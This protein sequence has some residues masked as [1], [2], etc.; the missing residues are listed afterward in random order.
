MRSCLLLV[1]C[2]VVAGKSLG[3]EYGHQDANYASDNDAKAESSQSNGDDQPHHTLRKDAK[4]KDGKKKKGK[5]QEN[6]AAEAA[7]AAAARATEKMNG[8]APERKLH[9]HEHES[10]EG[11]LLRASKSG[12]LAEVKSLIAAGV[13]V[14]SKHGANQAMTPVMWSSIKGYGEIITALAEAGANL[15]TK[16]QGG[17]NALIWA[18]REGRDGAVKAL[19][20]GGVDV[21]VKHK[22]GWDALTHATDPDV[23]STLKQAGLGGQ[24]EL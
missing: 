24:T 23:I 18:S 12:D 22:D 13:D 14:D 5:Q 21:H 4:K 20:K 11:R 2:V 6:K 19:I 7:R 1:I 10:L 16:C 3:N 17:W 9:E 15:E 8:K